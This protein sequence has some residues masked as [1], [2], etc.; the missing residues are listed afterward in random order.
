MLLIIEFRCV[1]FRNF[2]SDPMIFIYLYIHRMRHIV[3]TSAISGMYYCTESDASEMKLDTSSRR[4]RRRYANCS[5]RNSASTSRRA[6]KWR[7]IPE[8]NLISKLS[9]WNFKI[10][11]IST[12]TSWRGSARRRWSRCWTHSHWLAPLIYR[13]K[14]TWPSCSTWWNWRWTYTA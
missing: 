7:N 13:Y 6:A 4:W 5:A 2:L 9:P 1:Q 12:N 14:N 11:A 3:S 8:V 10:W